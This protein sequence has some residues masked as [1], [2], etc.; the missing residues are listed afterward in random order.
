MKK[1]IVAGGIAIFVLVTV[2]IT[3]DAARIDAGSWMLPYP[4]SGHN[5]SMGESVIYNIPLGI[6]AGLFVSFSVLFLIYVGKK[7][8]KVIQEIRA[9]SLEKG[10]QNG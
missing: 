2:Y 6:S 4:G 3:V 10:R 9:N 7:A 5:M 8:Y 1:Y